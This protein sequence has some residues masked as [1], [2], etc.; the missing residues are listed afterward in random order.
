MEDDIV[1]NTD[2]PK[3]MQLVNKSAEEFLGTFCLE[4]I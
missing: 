4:I 2:P 1:K 3:F